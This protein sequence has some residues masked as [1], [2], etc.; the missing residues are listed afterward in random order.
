MVGIVLPFRADRHLGVICVWANF[1]RE[2]SFAGRALASRSGFT[3]R[4]ASQ[5][6]YN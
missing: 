2:R 5:H 6:L 3:P 1:Q 4:K